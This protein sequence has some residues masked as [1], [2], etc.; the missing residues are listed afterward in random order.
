M[1]LFQLKDV[2]WKAIKRLVIAG[3]G[4]FVCY[5]FLLWKPGSVETGMKHNDF[6]GV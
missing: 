6:L 1:P 5:N 4:P 2:L 3:Y